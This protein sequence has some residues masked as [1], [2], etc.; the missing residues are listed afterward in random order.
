MRRV[1]ATMATAVLIVL[2]LATS[3][4]ADE[5]INSGTWAGSYLNPQPGPNTTG[6]VSVSGAFKRFLGSISLQFTVAT[7]EGGCAVPNPP[8]APAA[9]S[10]RQV[11]A[12]LTVQCNGVYTVRV[13][14]RS[15][16]GD[17]AYLDQAIVVEMP[18]PTVTGVTAVADGRSIEVS[19]D[20]MLA[21]APD[22]SGYVVERR[23]GDAPFEEIA[24]PAPDEQTYT[25]DA[26]PTKAGE[27]TYRVRTVRPVPGGTVTSQSSEEAATPFVAAP[28]G[29]GATG[30]SGGAG[31]SSDAGTGGGDG[32]TPGA[33]AATPDDAS[34]GSAASGGSGG[35]RAPR[36]TFSGT[37][38]PP[39]LRPTAAN[40]RPTTTTTVDGG[41]DETLPY[42]TESGAED[43][44]LADDEMASTYTDGTAG[45]GMVIPVATALVLAMWAV[46]LRML[47]RAAARPLG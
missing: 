18:A 12:A 37:F 9:A 22:I 23:I 26:L 14:A 19:W 34:G 43:P 15:Q 4:S 44:T 29:S 33:D 20:D 5:S 6:E 21:A 40:V 41:F 2:V 39:L 30:G 10:P 35:V 38:L 17:T 42:D 45:R 11:A 27:A 8:P 36:A 3:A 46:H 47:A 28:A 16:F 32:G 13:D 25:D 7:S 31:G 1:L 24:T